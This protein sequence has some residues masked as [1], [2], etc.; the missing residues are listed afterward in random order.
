MSVSDP[1]TNSMQHRFRLALVP[2]NPVPFPHCY[3][4]GLLCMAKMSILHHNSK[5]LINLLHI[6]PITA[7]VSHYRECDVEWSII[8]FCQGPYSGILFI[9]QAI[10]M[11]DLSYLLKCT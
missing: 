7:M 8:A 4:Y 2:Y 3:T 9:S 11:F 6:F 10:V 5:L 1:F